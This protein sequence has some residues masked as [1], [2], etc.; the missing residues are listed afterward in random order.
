MTTFNLISSAHAANEHLNE[1][2]GASIKIVVIVLIIWF[3]VSL[4]KK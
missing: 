1:G 2:G 4:F 3:I